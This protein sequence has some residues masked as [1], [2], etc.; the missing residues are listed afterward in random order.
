[1]IFQSSDQLRLKLI[2]TIAELENTRNVK[3][4]LL[5]MLEIA[6]KERDQ[7]REQLQILMKKLAS[8][9]SSM[10]YEVQHNNN[11]NN[12]VVIQSTKAKSS[13]TESNSPSH[14]SSPVDSF[15]EAVSSPEFSNVG[16]DSHNKYFFNQTLVHDEVDV[17]SRLIDSL[18]RGKVLP[19]KGKLLDA[20]INAGPLLQNLVLSGPL[21]T[22][23]NPPPL[24]S[25]KIPPFV[26]E[27][28]IDELNLFQNST[29][30]SSHSYGSLPIQNAADVTPS[31]C[32]NT[33]Q[34]T[35]SSSLKKQKHQC[36]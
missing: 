17:A 33:W 4:E 30:P 26:V 22:W 13:I 28:D 16:V 7:A 34:F 36:F 6:Y 32:N 31:S 25:I 35:S 9:N 12:N 5:N 19:Q 20:V 27:E 8:S 23:K 18:A 10:F 24:S 1:M 29:L 15:I 11:N 14:V 21:P 3:D 2:D